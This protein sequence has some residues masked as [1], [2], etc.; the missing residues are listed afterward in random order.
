MASS[1]HIQ[2]KQFV[3]GTLGQVGAEPGIGRVLFGRPSARQASANRGINAGW[4]GADDTFGVLEEAFGTKLGTGLL[5]RLV[6]SNNPSGRG[7]EDE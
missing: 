2:N 5:G 3:R 7:L 6:G 4:H 1:D